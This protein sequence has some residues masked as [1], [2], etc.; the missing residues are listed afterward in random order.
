MA[1]AELVHA[2]ALDVA[3]WLPHEVVIILG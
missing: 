3:P 2:S 1:L